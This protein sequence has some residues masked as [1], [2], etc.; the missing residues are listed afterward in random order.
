LKISF[1]TL[2]CPDRT[3]AQA[4]EIGVRA[5]YN[6]IELRFLEG[7]ASLWKLPS[8][9]GEGLQKT[10]KRVADSGLAVC[11]LDTSCRFDSPQK[12]ERQRWIDEGLRMAELAAELHSPGVRVFGDRIDSASTRDATQGWL[13]DSLNTLIEK[14]KHLPAGVWL[15]THGDFSSAAQL[16]S[17]L[18]A[19][20]NLGLVWDS[21]SAF[22][23]CGERPL[24]HGLALQ[25]SV[26]HVHIKDLRNVDNIWKPVLTGE[27]QFPLAEIRSALETMNYDGFLSFEWEK[28]W[29][30]EIELPEI[31]IPHFA[32]WFRG[33]W[34]NLPFKLTAG[35]RR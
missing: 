2:G 21:A 29:H 8:F 17:L 27:G 10:R 35:V 3:L 19:C 7:E 4:L 15:E 12:S 11:C 24:E 33:E 26:C 5:G 9:Q 22:I 14:T 25:S 32:N 6:G 1:S 34:E 31:A 13:V 20:P 18:S 16:Q 23:E 28:K 30:P